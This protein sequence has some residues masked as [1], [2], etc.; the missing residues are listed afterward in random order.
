MKLNNKDL[1]LL[2]LLAQELIESIEELEELK[3]KYLEFSK[4][5][6]KSRFLATANMLKQKIIEIRR[7]YR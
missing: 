2:K 3:I 7:G 1:T 5:K 4:T 6:E